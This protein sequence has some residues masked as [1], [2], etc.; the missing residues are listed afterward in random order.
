MHPL[1]QRR[2]Y[3]LRRQSLREL[4]AWLEGFAADAPSESVLECYQAAI[5][6]EQRR[7]ARDPAWAAGRSFRLQRTVAARPE[8]V[9]ARWTR[10]ELMRRWWSPEHFS[11][12]ECVAEPV[13]GGALRIVM[14]E[15]DGTRHVA[16]GRYVE[17]APPRTLSFELAPLDPDAAPLFAALHRVGLVPRRGRTTVMLA[18]RVRAVAPGAVPALAGMRIGW[19]QLLDKL[20]ADAAR[21]SSC[22]A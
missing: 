3:A 12:V 16:A 4:G 1:G 2:I 14:Q 8:A 10:P 19:G 18:I 21:D 13:P 20:A 17:L 9:W 5:D 7:A 22:R 11:V 6:A 15:G